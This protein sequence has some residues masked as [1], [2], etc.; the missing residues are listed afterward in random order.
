MSH[1]FD[2]LN[3]RDLD[4]NPLDAAIY[5]GRP[6]LVVNVASRCGLTP[7]YTDLVALAEE[8]GDTG[9]IIG[10]PCNQF[11]AQEPG[12]AEEIRSFCS[13]TYGVDF[14][15]LA[16]QDVNG[17]DRSPLY[18]HLVGDGADIEWNFGKFVVGVDGAV[19]AR[20]APTVNP[21]DARI[22]TALAEA[23]E[24]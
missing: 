12:S 9:V 1:A 21:R 15:L 24:G 11:G 7:Q 23:A 22:L 19:K 6:A 3:L 2:A 8:L 20:F 5:A 13:M 16:K 17:A 10:V 4:G 14:P 18:Q